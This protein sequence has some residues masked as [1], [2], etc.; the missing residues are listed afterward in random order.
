MRGAENGAEMGAY[1]ALIH[2][3]KLDSLQAK[4]EE[5]MPFGLLPVYIFET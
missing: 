1:N 2:S 3:I 4:V 5:Y